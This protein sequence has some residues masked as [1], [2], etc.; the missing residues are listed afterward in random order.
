MEWEGPLKNNKKY[1]LKK[2]LI[3]YFSYFR[4]FVELFSNLDM[5]YL[6]SDPIPKKFENLLTSFVNDPIENTPK[7]CKKFKA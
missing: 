4:T 2:T 5:N 3:I 7:K 1:L 6:C